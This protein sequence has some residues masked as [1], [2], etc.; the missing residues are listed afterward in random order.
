MKFA[1]TIQTAQD[2]AAASRAAIRDRITAD[3][4]RHVEEQARA[5]GYNSAAACAGYRD[6]TIAAWAEEAAAFIAWRDR[7][8]Q[9]AF[10]LQ[11]EYGSDKTPPDA[12]TVLAALPVFKR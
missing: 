2:L 8:W 3:I 10:A 4:D 1:L 11:A 12:E 7:V 5:L 9:T 6:S